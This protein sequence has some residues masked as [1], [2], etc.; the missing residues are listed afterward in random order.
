MSSTSPNYSPSQLTLVYCKLILTTFFWGGTF[1]AGK[2]LVQ[3]VPYIFAATLRF[4][5]AFV[6]L[7]FLL[8][9][10]TQEEAK[11][12]ASFQT[13][14][15]VF[16]LGL[17]GVY[18]YNISFFSALNHIE[19]SR[20]AL[21]VTFSP[22]LVALASVFLFKERLT[23]VRWL[24]IL[25]ALLGALLVISKGNLF[26][27]QFTQSFGMGEFWMLMAVFSWVTYSL[28]G[29]K[30][31]GHLSP[32]QATTQTC[33]WGVL[34]LMT[35][36]GFSHLLNHTTVD[37]TPLLEWKTLLSIIYLGIFG[38]AIGYVWYSDGIK[39]IGASRSAIF[40]NLVPVFGVL[41]GVL[42]LGERPVLSSLIG[43]VLVIFG[44]FLTNR[45]PKK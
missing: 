40:T 4:S 39:I 18:S 26:N 28:I 20:A 38:T 35:H 21:F 15:W 37:L 5:L 33:G 25:I 43:G 30:V 24:G 11:I 16:L 44:V 41:L 1:I 6:Y 29:K 34:L 2:Y 3:H 19:A 27:T 23:L 22:I 17:T 36:W 42:I 14:V 8:R 9:S 13:K 32:M 10:Q 7:F 12:P 31:L 45:I